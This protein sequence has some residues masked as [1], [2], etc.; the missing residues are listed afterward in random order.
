MTSECRH[1]N[2]A[3]RCCPTKSNCCVNGSCRRSGTRRSAPPAPSEHWAFQPI[4]RPQ[5]PTNAATHPVDALLQ[6]T[7][8]E[9]G[10]RAQGQAAR[11][12]L[13]RRLYLDLI[14]LPPTAQQLD[15]PRPWH[16]IVDELLSSPHHGER[17]ARH[18]MDVWR[19]CDWYGLGNQLRFSQ[20]H[21]W[22]WRDWIVNSLNRDK[23]YDR[24]ILEML[25]GDELAPTDPDAIV[26]TGF[27][28]R[29]YYLFNR[30]TWLDNTIEHTSK[31]FL[32]LT[33][34]CAKCHDHKY[35][36]ITQLD[37]YRFRAIFEPHQVRLD[38]VPGVTNFDQD[39]I[40]RVFDDHVELPTFLH[41]RG[42]PKNPDEDQVIQPG[43]PEILASFAPDV[44]PIDLPPSA[45][46]PGVRD[47][48]Q[49]DHLRRAEAEVRKAEEQLTAARAR[50]RDSTPNPQSDDAATAGFEFSDDFSQADPQAWKLSGDGW[51]YAEGCAS[52]N[53]FHA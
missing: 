45:Y 10:V 7:R 29:N 34:N 32:G 37:Y 17:W 23:G 50:R 42:D 24:M 26:A 43:V 11:G 1:L 16:V 14:G 40:P 4:V 39:G 53:D 13:L 2:R 35:D 22:H 20:K 21:L 27:L 8:V 30:T 18:W 5:L 36:P 46:A 44:E 33:M 3:R 38:P 49:R 31:A 28:A 51:Q 25:A 48:V 19:Y 15:D 47:H 6:A 52:S 12:I 41:V 9:K